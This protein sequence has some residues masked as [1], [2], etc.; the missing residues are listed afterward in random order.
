MTT[1]L[2]ERKVAQPGAERAFA[3]LLAEVMHMEQVP[4]ER[5]FFDELGADSLVMAHFCARVR[6]KGGL[7]PSAPSG[8]SS[9]SSISRSGR[10]TGRSACRCA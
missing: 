2:P 7:P 4:L 10:R 8:G 5:H 6:K 1:T 3:E 9:C